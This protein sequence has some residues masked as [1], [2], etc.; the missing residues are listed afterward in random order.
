MNT[1]PVD[2]GGILPPLPGKDGVHGFRAQ[3]CGLPRNDRRGSLQPL[4][5]SERFQIARLPMMAKRSLPEMKSI[6]VT[7]ATMSRIRKETCC[8]SSV[9]IVSAR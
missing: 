4:M 9:R 2:E 8:H 6:V 3:A 7:A 1:T 5:A